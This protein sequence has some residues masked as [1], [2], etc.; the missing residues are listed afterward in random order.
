MMLVAVAVPNGKYQTG[1]DYI[2]V[3]GN[4]FSLYIGGY[5]AVSLVIIDEDEDGR[6]TY[7]VEGKDKIQYGKWYRTDGETYLQL[8]S[9]T[10]KKV[11]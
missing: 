7:T 8:G 11:D 2:I 5:Y 4:R 3:S 6:F 10:L 9:R 1:N